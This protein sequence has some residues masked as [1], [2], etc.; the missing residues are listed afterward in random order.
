M[1]ELEVEVE[2]E[3]KELEFPKESMWEF[4]RFGE[5]IMIFPEN[6]VY[7]KECIQGRTV[8]KKLT[9]PFRRDDRGNF[10]YKLKTD[11]APSEDGGTDLFP[12]IWDENKG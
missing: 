8:N 1:V 12:S 10:Y 3:V 7:V 5:K 9:R 4:S 11:E 6:E 2:E